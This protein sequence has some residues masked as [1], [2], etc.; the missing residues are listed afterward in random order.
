[1]CVPKV[2]WRRRREEAKKRMKE[3]LVEEAMLRFF[4]RDKMRCIGFCSDIW[5]RI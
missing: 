4:G 5:G 2:P 1:M 3:N